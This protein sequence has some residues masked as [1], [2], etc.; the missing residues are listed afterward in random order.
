MPR[1]GLVHSTPCM[2][3]SNPM[4]FAEDIWRIALGHAQFALDNDGQRVL[5]ES[6]SMNLG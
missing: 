6:G 5:R 4:Q 2:S 1:R 3:R